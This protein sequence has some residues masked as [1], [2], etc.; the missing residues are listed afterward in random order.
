[1]SACDEVRWIVSRPE[2]VIEPHAHGLFRG[3]LVASV[4]QVYM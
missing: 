1:M 2:F 4:N 3:V